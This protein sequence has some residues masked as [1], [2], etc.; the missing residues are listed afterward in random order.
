MFDEFLKVHN[1]TRVYNK[2]IRYKDYLLCSVHR[3]ILISYLY[4]YYYIIWQF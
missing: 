3:F 1:F 2:I 4:L